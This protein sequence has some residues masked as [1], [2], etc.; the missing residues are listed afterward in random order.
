MNNKPQNELE[1]FAQEVDE[2]EVKSTS[3]SKS[4]DWNKLILPGAILIASVLISGAL[5][6]TSGKGQGNNQLA[7]IGD[8][9]SGPVNVS[10]DDDA[11]LGNKDAPVSR[12]AFFRH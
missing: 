7:A 10:A 9:P 1:M 5:I 6:F 8:Q 4:L 12:T 11:F 2:S 3:I